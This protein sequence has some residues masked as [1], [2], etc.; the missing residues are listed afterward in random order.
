MPGAK[1]NIQSERTALII[2]MITI[3]VS[4]LAIDIYTPSLPRIAIFFNTTHSMAM[5]TIMTYIIGFMIGE[6]FLGTISDRF[7]RKN[8]MVYGLILAIIFT[9]TCTFS[10]NIYM[11]LIFRILQ[12]AA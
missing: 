4:P 3:A 10:T 11:L 7:G 5:L 6:I 1:T 8:I 2:I 12:G 9:I